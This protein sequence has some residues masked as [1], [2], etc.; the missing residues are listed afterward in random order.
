MRGDAD[1]HFFNYGAGLLEN[2]NGF[3]RHLGNRRLNRNHI[4]VGA[5]GNSHALQ[6]TLQR[7]DVIDFSSRLW[8]SR[9]S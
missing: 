5:V 6:R 2:A 7:T 1:L 3:R 4:K 9:G 8:E